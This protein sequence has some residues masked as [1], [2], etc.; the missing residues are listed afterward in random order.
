MIWPVSSAFLVSALLYGKRALIGPLLCSFLYIATSITPT[1]TFSAIYVSTAIAL[2]MTLLNGFRVWILLKLCDRYLGDF[3]LTLDSPKQM[4]KLLLIAGPIGGTLGMLSILPTIIAVPELS[5]T[6]RVILM[7]RWWLAMTTGGMIF[8][9]LLLKLLQKKAEAPLPRRI[10]LLTSL[11]AVGLLFGMLWFIRSEI[12]AESTQQREQTEQGLQIKMTDQFREVQDIAKSITTAIALNPNLTAQDFTHLTAILRHHDNN[13]IIDFL[14]WSPVVLETQREDFEASQQCTLQQLD[15]TGLNARADERRYI[16][17]K[18]LIPSGIANKVVCFD[19]LSEPRRAAAIKR[20]INTAQPTL[21]P[22][23][24]LANDTSHGVL[25]IAPTYDNNDEFLGVVSLVIVLDKVVQNLQHNLNAGMQSLTLDYLPELSAASLLDMSGDR[26]LQF[27]DITLVDQPW[28]LSWRTKIDVVQNTYNWQINLFSTIG[29]FIV[30]LIQY[31]AYRLVL[32][33][34]LVQTEVTNKTALLEKAKLSAEQASL[35]KGQFLANMSHEIRTPLNAILGF[36]ELAKIEKNAAIKAEYIDGIWSSSEA[37]L[38]LVNDVLDYSKIEAGKLELH[39]SRFTV[40]QIAQRLNAIFSAQITAKGLAFNLEYDDD[41]KDLIADDARIQQILL[42]LCSNAVKFTKSGH[43][44]VA[45]KLEQIDNSKGI[46]QAT[47]EDTGIGIPMAEQHRVFD[48]FTQADSSISR[49]YG[50][51]GLGLAISY[52][53][54]R[55]LD[56]VITLQSEPDVGTVFQLN[57]PVALAD[58][59]QATQP[60]NRYINHRDIL[61]VDDNLINLKVTKALLQKSGFNVRT[62]DNGLDAIAA[63]THTKPDIVFMDMQ[64]PEL[65][66]LETTRRLRKI[67]TQE[68]LII[69][70]L[71]ANAARED[72][73]ECLA[74]GMNDHLAKPI[75][76]AKL[77]HCLTHWLQ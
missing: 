63:V 62:A 72:R 76:L 17:V 55:L 61:L 47:V 44:R 15:D 45:L 43:I 3:E 40:T 64:M 8:T 31:I 68:A 70:G 5:S 48:Q 54:T 74:A 25:L 1:Y 10:Y 2:V 41:P 11:G 24:E 27:F 23:I 14:S 7:L 38:S 21:T 39:P 60:T 6:F 13:K 51:T 42:N 57:V 12:T 28:R 37:L 65:D 9:P 36:S 53:L 69:V 50:G 77:S 52:S 19:L 59:A 20:A 71:T 46:L 75:S 67:F 30:I 18:Y 49:K 66:G 29:A 73:D 33:N 56:G 26:R 35:T 58:K 22:P 4:L 34:Q 32:M 16:P